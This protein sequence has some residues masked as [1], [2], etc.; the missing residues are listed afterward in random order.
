[1]IEKLPWSDDYTSPE[2]CPGFLA[3]AL[4]SVAFYP[5]LASIVVRASRKAKRGLYDDREWVASS[6]E[7][8][9]L[10]E[11]IGGRIQVE[12][13]AALDTLD[14][15]AV[16]VGNHMSTLETFVLPSILRPRGPVT[17]IVKRELVEMPVFKHVMISRNPVVV[18]RENPREDLRAMMDGGLERLRA[19]VSIIVF[20]QRTRAPWFA[21]DEFNSVGVKLARRA[22]VPVVPVALRSDLWG[23][24]KVVKDFGPIRPQLPVRFRF[25]QPM[26]VSGNGREEHETIVAFIVDNLRAWGVPIRS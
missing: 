5:G 21:P 13:T 22:G 2:P 25:G 11:R 10:I 6:A 7:V 16:Y 3:R 23:I 26:A 24:G 4:P 12:G 19:G 8:T 1:M 17:F 20:P 14:G 9:R 15:P 18:G